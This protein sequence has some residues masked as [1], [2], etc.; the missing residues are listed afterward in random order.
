MMEQFIIGNYDILFVFKFNSIL[1]SKLYKVVI[2]TIKH[3]PQQ[4]S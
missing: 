4:S 1:K 2:Y 3:L